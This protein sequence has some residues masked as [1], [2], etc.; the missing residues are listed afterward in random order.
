MSDKITSEGLTLKPIDV[1]Y[2]KMP[3]LR[4]MFV[5][6][7]HLSSATPVSRKDEYQNSMLKKIVDLARFADENQVDFVI[8]GGDVFHIKTQPDGFMVAV[9]L[10]LKTFKVPV[11]TIIGNHDILYTNVDSV[12]RTPLGILISSGILK[13]MNSIKI[14][15][16]D[17][18]SEKKV[19]I[20]GLDYHLRPVIPD[21][22]P[23]YDKAFLVAHQF[24]P[25]GMQ[26]GEGDE[27][28]NEGEYQRS[29][30][31]VFYLGHDHMTYPVSVVSGKPTVRPGALSRGTKHIQNRMRD[32]MFTVTDVVMKDENLKVDFYQ[33]KLKVLPADEIFSDVQIKREDVSKQ[34]TEFVRSLRDRELS[35]NDEIDTLVRNLCGEN[36]VLY[37]L[38]KGYLVNYGMVAA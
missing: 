29:K 19:L 18:N 21:R 1:T 30:W 34:M 24:T 14:T 7:P 38:V 3:Y 17:D 4:W 26:F 11:Y 32:V 10:A 28:F 22:L 9:T 12:R 16:G 31:D 36:E 20:Q 2:D 27:S 33:E 6:D 8:I 35:D 23:G 37:R 13:W 15:V 25:H 5:G